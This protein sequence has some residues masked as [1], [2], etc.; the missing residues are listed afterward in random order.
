MVTAKQIKAVEWVIDRLLEHAGYYPCDEGIKD[1]RAAVA[2]IRSD[3]RARRLE[4]RSQVPAPR[5]VL[6]RVGAK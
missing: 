3:Y 4:R 1:A 2:A 5:R 6:Q